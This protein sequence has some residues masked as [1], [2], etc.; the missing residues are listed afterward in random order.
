MSSAPLLS[1]W[2]TSEALTGLSTVN[3]E[4]GDEMVE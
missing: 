4:M 1:L 3:H 2:S